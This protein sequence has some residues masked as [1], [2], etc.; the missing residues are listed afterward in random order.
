MARILGFLDAAPERHVRSGLDC[1][2]SFI[3]FGQIRCAVAELPFL[4][5]PGAVAF[6]VIKLVQNALHNANSLSARHADT[7]L[8]AH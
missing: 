7:C 4:V 1:E 6:V 2:F 8:H 3:I 5:Y